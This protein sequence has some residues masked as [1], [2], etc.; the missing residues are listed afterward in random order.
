[1]RDSHVEVWGRQQNERHDQQRREEPS[2][3]SAVSR[4]F[5]VL[6]IHDVKCEHF[7]RYLAS[8]TEPTSQFGSPHPACSLREQADLTTAWGGENT[9]NSTDAKI[10]VGTKGIRCET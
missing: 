9:R 2:G 10:P 5:E 4:P 3:D 8:N 6:A 1:M 7:R